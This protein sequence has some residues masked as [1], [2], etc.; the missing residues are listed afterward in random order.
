MKNPNHTL[1]G[2][3]LM[4]GAMAMLPLMDV[5]A[6]YLGQMGLPVVQI[7]MRS[8]APV[9]GPCA[10]GVV[11]A[12]RRSRATGPRL[13]WLREG[14]DAKRQHRSSPDPGRPWKPR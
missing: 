10:H 5:F 13:T 6:K 14:F 3:G 8:A 9:R 1:I 11:H 12:N 2:I 4:L 7:D